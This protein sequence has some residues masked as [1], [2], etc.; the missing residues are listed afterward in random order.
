MSLIVI[1]DDRITN[2]NIFAKLA[3]SIE[4][5]VIVQ[6]FGDPIAALAWLATNKPD[7]IVTDYKMPQLDGAEFIRRLRLLPVIAEVPVVVITVYD[8]RSFR[9]RAL[10]T[11]ATDFLHSP[12]DHHE[13]VTRARNLLKMHR[14]Q[15]ELASRAVTLQRELEHSVLS[16]E[17]ALRDSSERLAQVIDTLPALIRATAPDGGL[18]F[19]NDSR[20]GLP[21]LMPASWR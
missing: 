2:R 15:I 13:F 21:G 1:V 6:A 11:G 18:L 3:A 19:V 7:L 5:G 17:S 12:V 10:E 20:R 9:L 14:Q 16:R 4:E 8:E